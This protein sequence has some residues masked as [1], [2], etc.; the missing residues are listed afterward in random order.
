MT[1]IEAINATGILYAVQDGETHVSV[2]PVGASVKEW[3]N[4]G[5]DS[6]WTKAL[7]SVI[8]GWE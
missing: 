2:K 7:Q 3:M 4:A 5:Y 6:V 1:T 8:I